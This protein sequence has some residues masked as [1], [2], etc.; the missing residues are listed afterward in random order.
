LKDEKIFEFY[1]PSMNEHPFYDETV[2]L[3]FENK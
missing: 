2:V 1:E 3:V